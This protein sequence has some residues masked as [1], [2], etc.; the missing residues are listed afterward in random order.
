MVLDSALTLF[1]PGT[2]KVFCGLKH[3]KYVVCVYTV[4]VYGGTE[5]SAEQLKV[6]EVNF[7]QNR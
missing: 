7:L 1:T 6:E 4:C 2:P 3:K 5:M